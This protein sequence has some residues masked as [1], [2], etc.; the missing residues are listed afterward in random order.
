MKTTESRDVIGF[1]GIL[2]KDIG[3]LVIRSGEEDGLTIEAESETMKR[4]ITEVEN[5]TLKIRLS[6]DWFDKISFGLNQLGSGAIRYLVTV[7]SL[8]RVE[9]M[10][11]GRVVA[12]QVSTDHLELKV[13]GAGDVVFAQFT[14]GELQVDLPG[15]GKVEMSGSVEHQTVR[16]SGAGAYQSGG[17]QSK[18][19]VLKLTGLGGASIR[20]SDTLDVDISGLGGVEYCGN[21]VVKSNIS[22]L[23]RL[24]KV[25]D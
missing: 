15:A 18:T 11:A 22:G 8:H 21:P 9:L 7:K 24:S 17:L 6:G 20:V 19:A 4:I 14:A 2:L 5:G 25:G 10:G 12:N 16:I 3:E 23:G 13:A 1:D